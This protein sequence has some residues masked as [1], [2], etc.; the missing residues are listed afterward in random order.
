MK[1]DDVTTKDFLLDLAIFAS[2]IIVLVLVCIGG[3]HV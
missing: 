1:H 2:V 3:G